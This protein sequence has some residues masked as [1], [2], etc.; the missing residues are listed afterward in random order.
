MPR[1]PARCA[2]SAGAHAAYSGDVSLPFRSRVEHKTYP[3]VERFNRLPRPVVFLAV[4]ALVIIGI[5]VPHVGFL[6]TLL[7]ALLVAF[8]VWSTWPLCTLPER[9]MRIA[10]LAII[11][12]LTIVQAFPRS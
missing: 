4:L 2:A 10:V 1:G 5:F 9:V 3:V 6:A 11:V 7:V 8:L 12:A